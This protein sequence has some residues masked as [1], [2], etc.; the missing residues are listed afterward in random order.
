MPDLIVQLLRI[1][2]IVDDNPLI[3]KENMNAATD[4]E[5]N[6]LI[7]RLMAFFEEFSVAGLSRLDD[8][9][10]QDIELVD[11]VH[12]LDGI[13]SLR[14]YLKKMAGGLTHFKIRYLNVLTGENAAYLTWEMDFASKKL[15]G[16][17]I[18]TVRGM[19]HVKF[20]RRIYYHEDSYDLGALVY[21]HLPLLGG[22]TRSLKRRM[23]DQDS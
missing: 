12:R 1:S 18:I 13:L 23:A 16:G 17:E 19:S 14:H 3:L 6:Q 20:T 21:E 5:T 8:I 22:V 15:R 7:S 2:T 4:I 9:C 11:P 10:T